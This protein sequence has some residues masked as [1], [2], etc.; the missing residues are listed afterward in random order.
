M[1]DR[2]EDILP[3]AHLF[4]EREARRQRKRILGLTTAA[5]TQLQSQPWPGNIREL[6]QTILRAV[7][8]CDGKWITLADL[9]TTTDPRHPTSTVDSL[10]ITGAFD[11]PLPA[12]SKAVTAAFECRYVIAKLEAA[13]GN[14]SRAAQLA[15]MA[16]PAF[17]KVMKRCGVSRVEF[18]GSS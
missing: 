4:V 10:D 9:A 2:S 15:G 5:E 8:F 18:V 16:R 11:H 12:A 6:K 7:L 13:D 14:V 17:R 1:R 3:L